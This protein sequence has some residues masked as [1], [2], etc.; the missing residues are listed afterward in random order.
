MSQCR[1]CS[2]PTWEACKYFIPKV[3]WSILTC[4]AWHL[5]GGCS[6]VS[7][8]LVDVVCFWKVKPGGHLCIS[9]S[10][11]RSRIDHLSSMF[12]RRLTSTQLLRLPRLSGSPPHPFWQAAGIR[13]KPEMDNQVGSPYSRSRVIYSEEPLEQ[14]QK[15]KPLCKSCSG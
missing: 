1:L 2:F 15:K 13:Y 9:Q 14:K 3:P 5:G 7:K 12:T 6:Q 8:A 10:V 4:R 11:E